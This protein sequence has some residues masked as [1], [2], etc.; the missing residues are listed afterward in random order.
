MTKTVVCPHEVVYISN[1][2]PAMYS[3]L[4]VVLFVNGYLTVL[5][6]KSEDT[7]TTQLARAYGGL[8]EG[9]LEQCL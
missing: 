3:D 4:S 7:I 6:E 5:A 9:W 8:R 1:G 2:Q